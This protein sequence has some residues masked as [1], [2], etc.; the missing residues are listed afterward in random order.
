MKKGKQSKYLLKYEDLKKEN[1]D[2]IY[3]FKQGAFYVAL[4]EDA[5]KLSSE[6]NLKTYNYATNVI[7]AGFNVRSLENYEKQFKQKNIKFKLIEL[8]KEDKIKEKEN[9]DNNIII[10]K[11]KKLDLSQTNPIQAFNFLYNIQKE[12]K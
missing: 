6:F 7:G 11:I 9:I 2:N 12:I 3:L 1:S 10:E 5:E 8:K 4:F